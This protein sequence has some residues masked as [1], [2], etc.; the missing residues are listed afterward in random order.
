MT[1]QAVVW[2]ER[3]TGPF[4]LVAEYSFLR[5]HD[6]VKMFPLRPGRLP[7]SDVDSVV[8]LVRPQVALMEMVAEN[9]QKYVLIAALFPAGGDSI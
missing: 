3:L 2:D 8:F 7:P 6:V 5:E 1:G 4:G 9:V